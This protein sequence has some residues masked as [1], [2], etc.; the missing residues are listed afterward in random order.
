[1]IYLELFHGRKDPSQGM[2]DWGEQ[3][4]IFGPFDYVHTIYAQRIVAGP[5]GDDAT[6]ELFVVDGLVY[7]DGMYYGDWSIY[8]P[9]NES[10]SLL[11]NRS[12]IARA[13]FLHQQFDERKVK[14]EEKEK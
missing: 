9:Y 3:G 12:E 11:S 1:M 14:K 6:L 7:Y 13:S 4:P 2:D 10:Q 5:F 8:S